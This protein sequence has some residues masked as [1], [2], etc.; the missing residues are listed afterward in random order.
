MN[1]NVGKRDWM[2]RDFRG[3]FYVLVEGEKTVVTEKE[4]RPI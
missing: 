3:L 2:I 1:V 4:S